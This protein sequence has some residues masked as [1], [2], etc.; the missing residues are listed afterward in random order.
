MFFK[1]LQTGLVIGFFGLIGGCSF[2]INDE[3][4]QTKT[5]ALGS[6]SSGCLKNFDQQLVDYFDGKAT[7]AQMT[8]LFGCWD[9]AL[10]LFVERTRGAEP[11]VYQV[12]ELQVFLERFFLDGQD[13]PDGLVREA[14]VLKQALLGGSRE[15]LTKQDVQNIKEIFETFES[16]SLTMLPYLPVTLDRLVER[17]PEEVDELARALQSSGHQLGS[18]FDAMAGFYAFDSF[19]KLLSEFESMLN[20]K[21]RSSSGVGLVRRNMQLVR[22]L[23]GILISPPYDGIHAKDWIRFLS[24]GAE[25]QAFLIQLSYLGQKYDNWMYGPGFK[26]VQQIADRGFDLLAKA[27]E[28][29]PK[30]TITFVEINQLL[31]ALKGF[32]GFPIRINFET[33]KEALP[34]LIRRLLSRAGGPAGGLANGLTLDGFKYLESVYQNW[35]VRQAHFVAIYQESAGQTEL[36]QWLMNS[37]EILQ[38]SEEL[39]SSRPNWTSLNDPKEIYSE[40]SAVVAILS[41]ADGRPFFPKHENFMRFRG[42]GLELDRQYGLNHF[43]QV[44]WRWAVV[45]VLMKGYVRENKRIANFEFL[46]QN[47]NRPELGST[48]EELEEFYYNFRQ[49]G[50]ELNLFDPR[51]FDSAQ[52]RF[53]ESNLFT[54]VGN[55]DGYLTAVEAVELLA[56]LVPAVQL[57][58][59]MH[60]QVSR[61]CPSP[62]NCG[63]RCLDV[64]NKPSIEASCY[65]NLMFYAHL[66]DPSREPEYRRYY[67]RMPSLVGYLDSIESLKKMKEFVCYFE[68]ATRIAGYTE[69]GINNARVESKDSEGYQVIAHYV[70]VIMEKYDLNKNGKIDHYRK[71]ELD[72]KNGK[73]NEAEL[74]Y[75]RFANELKKAIAKL[76]S[77]PGIIGWFIKNNIKTD[78]D[79]RKILYYLIAHGDLPSAGGWVSWNLGGHKKTFGG[80]RGNIFKIFGMLKGA[81]SSELDKENSPAALADEIDCT[82]L[83][84]EAV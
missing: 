4:P 74:I 40:H 34:V 58:H 36:S 29:R 20:S 81:L 61:A 48:L 70:E 32:D 16:I 45:E 76:A 31:D 22:A 65:R 3:A 41:A 66:K 63:R 18:T 5:V 83:S 8:E 19:E 53:R 10:D 26:T 79:R 21:N 47:L 56:I 33:V 68:K 27:I 50:V 35:L 14:M 46:H 52:K 1:P 6:D 43:S 62:S 51:Y 69:E 72:P 57:A 9:S 67:E 71:K 44:N 82:K 55:G 11:G 80:D 59:K 24:Q 77:K 73:P 42:P 23:K 28:V 78:E 2:Q 12:S 7:Q 38:V 17:S 13:L 39:L 64:F 75:K 15:Q 49:L 30:N 84:A 37:E 60:H 54:Y 25:W